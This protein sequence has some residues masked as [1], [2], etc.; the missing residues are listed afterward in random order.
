MT[1]PIFQPIEL[2]NNGG[3]V[4]FTAYDEAFIAGAKALGAKLINCEGQKG[5]MLT[6]AMGD[7]YEAFRALCADAKARQSAKAVKTASHVKTRWI[8]GEEDYGGDWQ[9]NGRGEWT[10]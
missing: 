6:P 2:K 3:L 9:R 1:R 4:A 10:R 7:K 8:G 5:W